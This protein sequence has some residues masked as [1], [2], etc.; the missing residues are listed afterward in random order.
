MKQVLVFFILLSFSPFLVAQ[1]GDFPKSWEGNWK[2]EINI[3]SANANH[4]VPVSLA[5]HP[6]DSARWSWI[7]H[8]E[9]PHQSPRKYELVKEKETWKIDEKNGIVLPQQFIGGRMVSSFSVGGN[10]L[11][12]YYWLEKN[13]LHMEIHAVAQNASG[14]SISNTEQVF[15]VSNHFVGSFQK[16]ILYRN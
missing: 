4:L 7:L 3:F 16:A 1:T 14:K 15:E 8:Y 6:V 5:I 10:L 11:I 12:C 9:A 2:G 13:A